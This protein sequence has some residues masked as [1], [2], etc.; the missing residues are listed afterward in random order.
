MLFR[1][2]HAVSRAFKRRLEPVADEGG[3]VG[4]DDRPG[5]AGD[6]GLDLHVSKYRKDLL[7]TLGRIAGL[8]SI[9]L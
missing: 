1:S 3:V 9:S 5:P 7:P 6:G 8:L 2:E 4:N